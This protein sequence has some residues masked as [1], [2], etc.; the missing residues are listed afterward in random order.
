MLSPKERIR[1]PSIHTLLNEEQTR[2]NPL[3]LRLPNP[4]AMPSVSPYGMPLRSNS[5]PSIFTAPQYQQQL[6]QQQLQ[7]QQLQ[8]QQLPMQRPSVVSAGSAHSRS[9][10]SS[11]SSGSTSIAAP[12][13]INGSYELSP[14]GMNYSPTLEPDNSVASVYVRTPRISTTSSSPSTS[15]TSKRPSRKRRANLPKKTTA[16]LL[17]WLNDNLD[18]PYPDS[19]EKSELIRATGLSSQQLSN[20]FIN[21]RRRKIQMLRDIKK[22]K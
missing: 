19:K 5:S 21:A 15:P 8:Q 4:I 17:G 9:S 7:Q 3:A 10:I 16:V 11:Y 6:Q 18:H 1:L 13:L 12:R 20:W 2:E 14:N 22:S